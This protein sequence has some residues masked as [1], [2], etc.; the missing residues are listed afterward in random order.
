MTR[1]S[2][3]GF[4]GG[5]HRIPIESTLLFVLALH[6]RPPGE[7]SRELPVL[8]SN[9]RETIRAIGAT[10]GRSDDAPLGRLNRVCCGQEFADSD[11]A[12]AAGTIRPI[13]VNLPIE[14]D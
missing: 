14:G 12:K 5:V 10:G 7:S 2:F 6:S 11:D 8:R 9:E 4:P 13:A 3:P 1:Q